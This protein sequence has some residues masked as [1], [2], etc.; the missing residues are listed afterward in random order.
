MILTYLLVFFSV[1]LSGSTVL[2]F[3]LSRRSHK[4][5]LSFSGS[6]LL[7]MC[8]LHLLPEIYSAGD[9]RIGWFI[10]G[11]FVLQ[12]LLEL[13]TR[14]LEHGHVHEHIHKH[15]DEDQ[16]GRIPFGLMM[17]LCLHAFFEG[18]PLGG[19]LAPDVQ[20]PLLAGIV[21]HN[22][23]VSIAFMGMLLHEHL[24]KPRAMFLLLVFALMSPAGMLASTLIGHELSGQLNFWF[25]ALMGLVVGI[26]LHI[27][28]TILF[29]STESHRFNTA[30]FIAIVLG[31][32][33]ALLVGVF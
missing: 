23:P 6:F 22:I 1:L 26:F 30:K 11:G 14:G 21:M 29:E 7:A 25:S 33:I 9:K 31:M 24:P 8:V 18:M 28:T 15:G 16:H 32:G 27:S 10:L 13:L 12:L 5:L 19:T 4:L 3:K 17:G 2:L 20:R